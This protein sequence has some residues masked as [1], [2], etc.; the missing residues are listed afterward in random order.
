[1]FDAGDILWVDFESKSALDLKAAGAFCYVND[2]ATRAI[3]L[4]YAIGN[5]RART[6]HSHG[7]ISTGTTRQATCARPSSAA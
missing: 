7:A 6:W 3:V 2:R 4:A 1:M 5:A